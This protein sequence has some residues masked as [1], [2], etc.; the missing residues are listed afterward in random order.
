MPGD[1][2]WVN[3]M[4]D[5]AA[6]TSQLWWV[7][8]PRKTTMLFSWSGFCF[9]ST[10]LSGVCSLRCFKNARVFSVKTCRGKYNFNCVFFFLSNLDYADGVWGEYFLGCFGC[11][12]R[13]IIK[14]NRCIQLKNVLISITIKSSVSMSLRLGM[15]Q[16]LNS[17]IKV[18]V[19]FYRSALP[20]KGL[21][22][23]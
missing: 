8:S 20:S 14:I 10:S 4:W 16:W 6:G 1:R 22:S 23:L 2:I 9:F 18:F 7:S 5:W 19:S 21:M 3:K 12:S 15:S 17:G 11:M 13:K